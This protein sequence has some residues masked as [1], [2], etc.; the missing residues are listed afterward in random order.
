MH[1]TVHSFDI[2]SS[3]IINHHSLKKSTLTQSLW[4]HH[5]FTLFWHIVHLQ[6]FNFILI[7]FRM[8]L[9]SLIHTY[10]DDSRKKHIQNVHR[11]ENSFTHFYLPFKD[12]TIAVNWSHTKNTFP[13]RSL[14]SVIAMKSD[15]TNNMLH[16]SC[17]F[18]PSSYNERLCSVNISFY[19]S[20]KRN[21][22]DHKT[23]K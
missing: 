21:I 11:N 19:P 3:S 7:L 2:V 1:N 12:F 5:Q 17:P 8:Q 20:L 23:N 16:I 18:Y 22:Y 14:K 13:I 6:I 4:F 15:A 10:T 9:D